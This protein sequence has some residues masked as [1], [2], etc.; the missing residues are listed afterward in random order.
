MLSAVLATLSGALAVAF[1]PNGWADSQPARDRR[2][3]LKIAVVDMNQILEQYKKA[4]AHLAEVKDAVEARNAKLQELSVKGKD[5]MKELQE[6]SFD[7]SSKDYKDRETKLFQIDSYA[8]SYRSSA[9]KEIQ[10]ENLKV[11]V[12]LNNEIQDVV[13]L[14]C[15]KNG[16]TH[17]VRVDNDAR[18]L[19]DPAHAVRV[20]N[21]DVLFH[22]AQDDITVPV[23][24]YLNKRY[25]ASVAKE[26][27]ANGSSKS[28]S[29]APANTGKGNKTK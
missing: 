14:F 9:E 24:T 15:E 17:V 3:N 25:A 16:F 11:V 19:S 6:S 10:R 22:R 27:D 13:K 7:P 23:L 28:E 20:V 4:E 5:L 1:P 8:K 26:S 18:T 21:Q 29:A 2:A 12:E